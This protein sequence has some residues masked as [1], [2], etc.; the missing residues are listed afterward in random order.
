M[1]WRLTCFV[2]MQNETNPYNGNTNE[3][4][5]STF[6]VHTGNFLPLSCLNFVLFKQ[7][8]SYV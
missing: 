3:N 6:D 8:K 2:Y 7:D 4:I 1:F 5:K